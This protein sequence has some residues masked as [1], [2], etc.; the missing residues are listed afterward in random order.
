VQK[1][2]YLAGP[3]SGIAAFNFPAFDEAAKRLREKGHV[4]VSPAELDDES[5]RAKA[6][7]SAD[8]APDETLPTWGQLLARDVRIVADH[9]TSVALL[10]GWAKSRGAR[11]ECYVAMLCGHDLYLYDGRFTFAN[12]VP[13]TYAEAKGNL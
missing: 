10:P 5:I 2:I 12:L 7:A 3:M 1:V 6:L 4:I 8:G 11:L 13:I 9:C